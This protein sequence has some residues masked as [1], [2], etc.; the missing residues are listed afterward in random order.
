MG[1]LR[2]GGVVGI[3]LKGRCNVASFLWPFLDLCGKGR[4]SRVS[5]WMNTTSRRINAGAT[6]FPLKSPLAEGV[7]KALGLRHLSAHGFCNNQR[8]NVKT[9]QGYPMRERPRPTETNKLSYPK[10]H[11]SVGVTCTRPPASVWEVFEG[12]RRKE[13]KSLARR[14]T[15]PLLELGGFTSP[16]KGKLRLIDFIKKYFI[17]SERMKTLIFFSLKFL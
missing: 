10:R 2:R 11:P 4:E 15:R 1:E 12:A 14:R 3:D 5:S 7:D 6:L 17:P 13:N 9:I 16:K 8:K